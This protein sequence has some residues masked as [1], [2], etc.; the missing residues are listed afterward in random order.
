M[1]HQ[2]TFSDAQIELLLDL[3]E[4]ERRELPVE[5]RHTD[6]ETVHEQ[7]RQRRRMVE[8]LIRQLQPLA[9]AGRA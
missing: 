4:T 2:P 8:E 3:L 7:L 1:T 5:I 9:T 6:N